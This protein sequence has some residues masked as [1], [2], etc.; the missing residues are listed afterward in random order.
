[1]MEIRRSRIGGTLLGIQP[2]KMRFGIVLRFPAEKIS[3]PVIRPSPVVGRHAEQNG[4]TKHRH[5]K[6]ALDK[7]HK[8]IIAQPCGKHA[9]VLRLRLAGRNPDTCRFNA[10]FL[11]IEARQCLAKG[12]GNTIKRIR[13]DAD[14]LIEIT[15]HRMVTDGMNRTGVENPA[16]A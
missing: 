1:M 9:V 13:P 3:R 2:C 16:A 4:A 11:E 8:I 15:R 6:D 12:L 14:R 7:P 10:E 5:G